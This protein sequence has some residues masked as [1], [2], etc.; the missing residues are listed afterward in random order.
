[1]SNR[2][3]PLALATAVLLGAACSHPVGEPPATASA[4]V[5]SAPDTPPRTDP[6]SGS[7]ALILPQERHF[8][9]LRQLTFGGENAEAYFNVEETELIFQST[10]DGAKCDQIFAMSSDGSNVRRVSNGTGRT[11]CGYFFP[12]GQRILF[13]STHGAAPECLAAPDRSHGYVWK[14][15]DEFDIY[16]ANADGSDIRPLV[17]GPGY[18]A[19]ATISATADRIVFTSTRTGDPELYSMRLDGSDLRQLTKTKGY[20][21]GAF[22]SWDGKKIV[23]RA[24]HPQ[25]PEEQ[26]KYDEIIRA[27]L[28]RPTRLELFVMNADGSDQ[29]QITHNGAANFG[30]FWHPD[31]KH[32]IF[33]SNV[34]D[35]KGRNFDLYLIAADGSNLERVT[36]HDSFDGFP[37]FTRDGKRLVF[38]SNRNAAALGDT[39]IFVVTWKP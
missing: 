6:S 33:S 9:E 36:Y 11:T 24:N 1:M 31:G 17:R 34:D 28:V 37:M 20:D 29:V 39:N 38:A 26:A 19:E 16:S 25:G 10:R 5:S 8:A 3:M 23:Y 14:L 27:G 7:D 22:F 30:P 21:G 13:A 32:I 2:S 35:P 15:Y 12:D 18:D 4:G